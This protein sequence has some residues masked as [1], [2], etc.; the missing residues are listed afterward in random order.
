[1][2]IPFTEQEQRFLLAEAIKTSSIPPEKLLVILNESNVIPNWMLMQV[3]HGRNLAS[4]INTFES[5][6]GRNSNNLTPQL[7][8]PPF[9]PGGSPDLQNKRKSVSELDLIGVDSSRKRRT[10]GL[11]IVSAQR[12]I[13]PKPA[14]NGSPISFASPFT[15][16]APKKRGRPSKNDLKIRQAEEIARGEILGSLETS[17]GSLVSPSTS[18]GDVSFLENILAPVVTSGQES[19]PSPVI[20]FGDQTDSGKKKRGQPN[21]RSSNV[22]RTGEGSFPIL[23][24]QFPQHIQPLQRFGTHQIFDQSMRAQFQPESRELQMHRDNQ[25]QGMQFNVQSNIEGHQMHVSGEAHKEHQEMQYKGTAVE[26]KPMEQH[27]DEKRSD[28]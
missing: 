13:Q 14:A 7:P 28:I 17:K 21:C 25:G 16:Q 8:V 2:E 26:S 12:N 1:M 3:P 23:P 22:P 5:L 27:K 10:P 6:A 18:G 15:G 19:Q 24:A 9:F 20:S 11:D 4:C